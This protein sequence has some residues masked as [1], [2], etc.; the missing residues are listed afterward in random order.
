MESGFLGVSGF[1]IGVNMPYD[2]VREAVHLVASSLGHLRKSFGLGLVLEGIAR[3][4][5]AWR[6]K[7]AAVAKIAERVLLT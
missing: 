4:V 2:I 7:S 5:D 3:E 1:F 6:T